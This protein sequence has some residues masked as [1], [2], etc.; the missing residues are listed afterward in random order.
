MDSSYLIHAAV[1]VTDFR[2]C[3]G[4]HKYIASQS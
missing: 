4:G 1:G 3:S 2:E